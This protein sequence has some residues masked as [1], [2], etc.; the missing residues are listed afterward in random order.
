MAWT[1]ASNVND[2]TFTMYCGR[3]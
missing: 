1:C 2:R 3:R